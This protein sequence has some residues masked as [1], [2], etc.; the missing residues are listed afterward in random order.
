MS[1]EDRFATKLPAD[2][3]VQS[4]FGT[5]GL[6]DDSHT[7]NPGTQGLWEQARLYTGEAS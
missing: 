4:G 2:P 5:T 6:K 3:D 7:F 1:W